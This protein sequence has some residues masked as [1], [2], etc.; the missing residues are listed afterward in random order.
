MSGENWHP[1]GVEAA[2]SRMYRSGR[3]TV[4]AL[5][6]ACLILGAIA[7]FTLGGRGDAPPKFCTAE[8]RL[9]PN[10]QV[11]GRDAAHDCKFVDEHGN[12]LPGQ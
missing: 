2:V 9:G 3:F 1:R 8:G 5:V 6:L 11:Y 12:V 10:G 7:L 4:A